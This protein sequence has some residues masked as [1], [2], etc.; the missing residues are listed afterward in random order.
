MVTRFP[1]PP[2][3]QA[4]GPNARVIQV[5]IST[6][7]PE[8]IR[9]ALVE[10][11]L[12]PVYEYLLKRWLP[13]ARRMLASSSDRQGDPIA[14][15]TPDRK[16]QRERVDVLCPMIALLYLG[17]RLGKARL[18]ICEPPESSGGRNEWDGALP[19]I[20]DALTALAQS[21]DARRVEQVFRKLE[22]ETNTIVAAAFGRSP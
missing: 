22:A 12:L 11:G 21:S 16:R 7:S 17:R 1:I 19:T 14:D 20:S 10:A 13:Y 5:D 6:A 2:S 4:S 3:P 18:T 9:H 8:Q 15:D